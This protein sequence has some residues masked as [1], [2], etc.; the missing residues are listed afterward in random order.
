MVGAPERILLIRPSALGDVCRTASVLASL[1]R[2]FPSARID[3]LVRDLFVDAVRA[4]PALTGVVAFPRDGLAGWW[5]PGGIAPAL[6]WLR[7]LAEPRYDLV[8]D[9]QG[10]ARSGIFT[11]ATRAPRR[12]GD[13]A[14][15][16][17]ASLAYTQRVRTDPATHVVDRAL[18]IARAAG[19]EPVPDARLFVPRD[20]LAPDPGLAGAR[21]AVFAP[22]SIWAGKCWPADRFAALA[23]RILSAGIVDR[24]A[25]VG[26]ERERDAAAPITRRAGADP[27]ILDLVGRTTIA[28]LM[29]LIE[30]ASLVAANDSAAT[31][32]A[33]GF[34]RPLVALLGP[35][36]AALAGPYHRLDAV[37]QRVTE[38]DRLTR[39]ACKDAGYGA[40]LMRRI[41]IDD[42]F[43]KAIE[44]VEPSERAGRADP[45]D[46]SRPS[47]PRVGTSR[48]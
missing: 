28:E 44:Q 24:V 42:A 41:T 20:V 47:P 27:R 17:F 3:W 10:L 36:D 8:L 32:M 34:A 48:S 19:A 11:R 26:A 33:V 22:T 23:D 45:G 38:D 7:R 14:A 39:R 29:R 30:S 5:K 18:E 12:L 25:V 35:T 1:R 40:S 9:C 31:H 6:R 37:V 13:R 4:H 16:E 46:A 21:Y 15:A 2:A 43:A